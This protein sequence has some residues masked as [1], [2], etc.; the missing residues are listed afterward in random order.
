MGGAALLESWQFVLRRL[1]AYLNGRQPI[2][3]RKGA[4]SKEKFVKSSSRLITIAILAGLVGAVSV[5]LAFA[6]TDS[7][8]KEITTGDHTVDMPGRESHRPEH[9]KG[10]M[11]EKSMKDGKMMMK[12]KP[13]QSESAHTADMPGREPHKSSPEDAA[14]PAVTSPG[15]TADMPGREE[16]SDAHNKK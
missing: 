12:G 4:L 11:K 1:G 13:V 6:Q 3:P 16:H 10:H 9:M 7:Q 14:G 8:K 5:P 2:Q 15:H